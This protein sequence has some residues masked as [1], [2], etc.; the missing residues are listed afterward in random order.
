MSGTNVTAHAH[1][2]LRYS[3]AR[4]PAGESLEAQ[5][6]HKLAEYAENRSITSVVPVCDPLTT[7]EPELLEMSPE[8][9]EATQLCA[10]CCSSLPWLQAVRH[11]QL[12]RGSLHCTCSRHAAASYPSG[13]TL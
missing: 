6:S 10:P 4:R 3:R 5:L 7:D 1:Q 12:L 8:Q 9:A 13:S 11:L 2:K